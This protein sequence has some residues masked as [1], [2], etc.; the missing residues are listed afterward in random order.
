VPNMLV[1][2][3]YVVCMVRKRNAL[4]FVFTETPKLTFIFHQHPGHFW[5]YVI[6]EQLDC[7][8]KVFSN[9]KNG[10]AHDRPR[11]AF[12]RSTRIMVP[13]AIASVL[14]CS[15]KTKP[16]SFRTDRRSPITD[17]APTSTLPSSIMTPSP[18]SDFMTSLQQMGSLSTTNV[19]IMSDNA[20]IVT[21]HVAAHNCDHKPVRPSRWAAET[22]TN[23]IT[24]T[25]SCRS[26]SVVNCGP[27][28][29]PSRQSSL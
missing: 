28:K 17:Q 3:V 12:I 7:H 9:S 18:L 23:H 20:R 6:S 29:F 15:Q 27:P 22:E 13:G 4:W 11:H 16:S 5:D 26:S 1:L 2:Y 10:K 19:A 8:F 24:L 14:F 25:F 21:H